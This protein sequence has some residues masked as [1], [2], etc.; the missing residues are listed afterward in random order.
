MCGRENGADYEVTYYMV[1]S[2]HEVVAQYT[3]SDIKHML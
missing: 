2:V 1:R 3:V